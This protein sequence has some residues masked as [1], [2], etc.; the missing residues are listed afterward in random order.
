MAQMF[1]YVF[2]RRKLERCHFAHRN[3]Y[4]TVHPTISWWERGRDAK[5]TTYC[6][7]LYLLWCNSGFGN[8][9]VFFVVTNTPRMITARKTWVNNIASLSH[10]SLNW[11]ETAKTQRTKIPRLVTHVLYI[12]LTACAHL[13]TVYQFYRKHL[14]CDELVIVSD[15]ELCMQW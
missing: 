11:K 7:P 4:V 13:T 1:G 14:F 10:F 2:V 8:D 3:I 15:F 9:N 6:L 12:T 5:V